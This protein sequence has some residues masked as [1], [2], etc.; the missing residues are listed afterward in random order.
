[1]SDS[2]KIEFVESSGNVFAD[3]GLSNPE[4]RLAKAEL[5]RQIRA[6]VMER[7]LTQVEAGTILGLAQPNVSNLMRGRLS[8]F[9]IER[10][11]AFLTSLDR[12]VTIVLTPIEKDQTHGE[13]TVATQGSLVSPA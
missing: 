6:I 10:L 11:M 5:A 3:L 7:G 8:G 1:M 12:N 13:I 9:S 2:D 4:E